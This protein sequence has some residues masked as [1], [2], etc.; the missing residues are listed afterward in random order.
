MYLLRRGLRTAPVAAAVMVLAACGGDEDPASDPAPV[1]EEAQ[2]LEDDE[3]QDAS[4]AD[5][6]PD[7]VEDPAADLD[8]EGLGILTGQADGSVDDAAAAIDEALSGGEA[9]LVF[10][11]DHAQGAEGAGLELPATTLLAVDYPEVSATLLR[12]EPLMGLDLPAKVLVWDDEDVTKVGVN[13]P[14]FLAQR[15]EMDVDLEA[16]STL[17]EAQRDTLDAAGITGLPVGLNP[18]GSPQG[19]EV[20][21]SEAGFEAT[22]ERA[23][24]AIE[25]AGPELIAEVDHAAA[26]AEVDVEVGANTLLVFG[27]P[28]VGTQLMTSERTVG[29]DLPQKLL[30]YEV[31]GQTRVAY[32]EPEYLEERHLL[33]GVEDPLT[34]I[35][36]LLG[37]LA[38]AAT[39]G[40]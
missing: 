39:S 33:A 23:R 5:D 38:S 16:L 1:D 29:I 22:L 32:N 28:Q 40:D 13:E 20:I 3:E 12:E 30:I 19:V 24:S 7:E 35:G 2:D 31:D 26:A 21:D 17:D 36:D 34:G 9:E 27:N 10:E 11:V 25:D 4:T 18:V 8:V 14:P 15:Y 37:D 6:E